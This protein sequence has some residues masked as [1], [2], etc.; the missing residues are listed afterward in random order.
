MIEREAEM[1]EPMRR[2]LLLASVCSIAFAA[3]S[4]QAVFPELKGETPTGKNINLP[5][6]AK[7]KYTILCLAFDRSAGDRLAAWFEPAYLRFVSKHGLFAAEY[8]LNIWFVPM[9]TGMDK[10]AYGPVMKKVQKSEAPEV[11]DHILFFQGDIDVYVKDLAMT[12][13]SKP[14]LF[15]LDASGSIVY[16]TEGDFTDDKLDAI[17]EVLPL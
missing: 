8:D 16:R 1:I 2:T 17:E 15:V 4:Q 3:T 12:D 5:K 6:D 14:Y 11:L 9:F 10:A 7:G 13:K